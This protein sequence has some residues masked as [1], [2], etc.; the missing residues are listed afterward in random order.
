[1]RAFPTKNNRETNIHP[2]LKVRGHPPQLQKDMEFKPL[3]LLCRNQ[4]YY[5]V[6]I[7]KL[8][9]VEIQGCNRCAFIR[10]VFDVI[11]SDKCLTPKDMHQK[12]IVQVR[13]VG[14]YYCLSLEMSSGI[15]YYDLLQSNTSERMLVDL[16]G[17]CWSM[18]G[19][20][21]QQSLMTQSR[22]KSGPVVAPTVLAWINE[23]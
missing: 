3:C 10:L 16:L 13:V 20:S 17:E 7:K 14:S 6:Q 19:C 8:K 11:T 4:P 2:S 9:N 1:M 5:R 23:V 15:H 22:I 12:G 18:Y 21:I